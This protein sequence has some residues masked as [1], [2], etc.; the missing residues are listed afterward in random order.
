MAVQVHED[1][2]V[3]GG[4]DRNVNDEELMTLAYDLEPVT[5]NAETSEKGEER[6]VSDGMPTQV[7]SVRDGGVREP[8]ETASQSSGVAPTQVFDL[9]DHSRSQSQAD[10]T[11]TQTFDPANSRQS[12]SQT[13]FVATQVF[14]AVS[15]MH[16]N[17]GGSNSHPSHAQADPDT[18]VFNAPQTVQ[19]K[20]D[21]SPGLNSRHSN[22]QTD[23]LPT[24]VFCE[25]TAVQKSV[26]SPEQSTQTFAAPTQ[27]HRTSGISKDGSRMSFS[28]QSC[29]TQ[30]FPSEANLNLALEMSECNDSHNDSGPVT[31]AA[32]RRSLQ[33]VRLTFSLHICCGVVV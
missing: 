2:Q 28:P 30:V 18:K 27:P 14:E 13:D 11:A 16:Q 21:G 5:D 29:S 15:M 8:S 4:F 23:L 3:S 24:Q 32:V 26:C 33:Q 12:N 31:P 25:P 9:N 19:R 6:Q 1:V 22:S 10:V 20:S 17:S 7:M